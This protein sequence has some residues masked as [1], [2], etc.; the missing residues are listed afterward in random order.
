MRIRRYCFVLQSSFRT[1]EPWS[2]SVHIKWH[3]I[4]LIATII[5]VMIIIFKQRNWHLLNIAFH[6]PAIPFCIEEMF[7]SIL[8]KGESCSLK[9][10][11]FLLTCGLQTNQITK[12]GPSPV[13]LQAQRLSCY[14]FWFAIWIACMA[15]QRTVII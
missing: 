3:K 11:V 8:L 13:S 12:P 7:T 1:D 15:W 10:R 5:Y 4:M 6:N 2:T 9:F 14:W